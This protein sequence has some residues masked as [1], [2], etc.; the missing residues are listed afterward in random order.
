[1]LTVV[2]AVKVVVSRKKTCKE[3]TWQIWKT[4]HVTGKT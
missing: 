3:I 2:I 1:M 4:G